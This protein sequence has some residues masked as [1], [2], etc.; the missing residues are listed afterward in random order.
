MKKLI[1]KDV[2][3]GKDLIDV[4]ET[5]YPNGSICLNATYFDPELGSGLPFA[6]F[7]LNLPVELE[8]DEVAIKSYSEGVEY[9]PWLFSWD[10][11]GHPVKV[12]IGDHNIQIPI[13][14]YLIK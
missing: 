10:I 13:C 2:H 4:F 3:F 5:R 9:L 12:V 6:T 11:V 7:T 14:K 1:L 8:D